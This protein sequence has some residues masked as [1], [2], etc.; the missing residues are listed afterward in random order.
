MSHKQ[1][2]NSIPQTF[3]TFLLNETTK[4]NWESSLRDLMLELKIPCIFSLLILY[5]QP[6][7]KNQEQASS[8]HHLGFTD[9]NLLP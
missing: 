4:Q 1:H 3:T 8:Y 7:L 9:K 2:F 5:P 6:I